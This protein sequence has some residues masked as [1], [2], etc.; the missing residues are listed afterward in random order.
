MEKNI[1]NNSVEV[2]QEVKDLQKVFKGTEVTDNGYCVWI[3]AP[4]KG[5]L[6]D[7]LK[8]EGF[9]FSPKRNAWWRRSQSAGVPAQKAPKAQPKA[10]KAQKPETPK[11]EKVFEELPKA[12]QAHVLESMGKAYPGTQITLKGEWVYVSGEA[13]RV[14]KDALKAEGLHW[15]FKAKA[16]CGP[17]PA[18]YMPAQEPKAPEAKA[19]STPKAEPFQAQPKAE[20]P[21]KK[22]P[23]KKSAPVKGGIVKMSTLF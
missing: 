13:A 5:K 1:A 2:S 19:E 20:K 14:C 8:A 7:A 21:A 4:Q 18:Q 17:I 3:V 16:W 15:G 10:E 12:V 23:A 9:A 6:T 11:A 22:S